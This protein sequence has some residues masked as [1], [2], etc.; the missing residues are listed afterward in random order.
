M[1]ET[2]KGLLAETVTKA[3]VLNASNANGLQTIIKN[4]TEG[5]TFP[6]D[7]VIDAQAFH[8]RWSQGDVDGDIFR[9]VSQRRGR[10]VVDRRYAYS[11]SC[12]FVGEG[13]LRNGQWFAS[14]LLAQ[15]HGAHGRPM[16]G[17]AGKVSEG[18]FSIILSKHS[19]NI[20]NGATLSYW[21]AKSTNDKPTTNT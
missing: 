18:V 9:G 4:D 16:S 7:V 11:R 3:R 6:E 13:H 20:D 1:L 14:Q 5:V 17:I 10:W 8:E 15:V 19:G 12:D 21:G 2:K